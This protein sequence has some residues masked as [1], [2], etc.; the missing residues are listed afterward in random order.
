MLRILLIEDDL[1][2]RNIYKHFLEEAGYAVVA[3]HSCWEGLKW[4]NTHPV[5]LLITDIMM[6]GIDGIELIQNLQAVPFAPPII[7]I[8]GG[9]KY[10]TGHQLLEMATNLGVQY[11]LQKP[12]TKMELLQTVKA[13]VG[14]VTPLDRPI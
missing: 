5:D 11:T 12:F 7:A 3:L 14:D 8:T 9:A 2:L 13:A 4:M 1:Q 10:I 6:P